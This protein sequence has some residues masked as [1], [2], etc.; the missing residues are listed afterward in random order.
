[1]R[2]RAEQKAG[3]DRLAQIQTELKGRE[4]IYDAKGGVIPLEDLKPDKL[5]P[6]LQMPRLALVEDEPFGGK[7]KEKPTAKGGRKGGGRPPKIDF[8]RNTGFK[9]LDSL[10]PPLVESMA[11]REGVKL[12]EGEATKGGEPRSAIPDK[13][14]RAEF[15]A[16]M[17]GEGD[18]GAAKK[19]MADAASVS[20][21]PTEPP[22]PPDPTPPSLKGSDAAGQMPAM[23][24]TAIP[25]STRSKGEGAE[26]R[27]NIT[28]ERGGTAVK[29][30]LPPPMMPAT[31]GFG[32]EL[33]Y[34]Q[35]DSP[36][37]DSVTSK[38]IGFSPPRAVPPAT[39][40]TANQ[41]LLKQMTG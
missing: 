27:N 4:Y 37:K 15:E 19:S 34:A 28:R 7:G 10:Q 38:K 41:T 40:K 1:M 5:P 3:Q 16:R 31:V 6:Y 26:P 25:P 29:A 36:E 23:R 17:S 22:P 11:I 30:R 18:T 2:L 35:P 20:D 14:S 24:P 32:L 12:I 13:M 21:N 9:E 39:V 33:P 8:G